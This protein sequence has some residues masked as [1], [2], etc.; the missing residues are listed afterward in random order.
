MQKYLSLLTLVLVWPLL[1]AEFLEVVKDGRSPYVVV[2]APDAPQAVR[3][4]ADDLREYIHKATG[5]QLPL[6]EAVQAA[7]KPSFRLGFLPVEQ[8]EGFVVKV[9][10][11]D[12]HISGNDTPGDPYNIHWA[13]GARVG[14]WYGVCD[15]LEKQLGVR[16]FMPGPLG[17]YVPQCPDLRVAAGLNYADAPRFEMR[18]MGYITHKKMSKSDARQCQ[19]WLR[20]NRAG[21]A[22]S[23]CAWHDWLFHFKG[24]DYFQEHPEWFALIGGRRYGT[25]SLGHGLKMCTTNP[26]AL[27]Q[28][29]KN[30]IE[31]RR[32][33]K[34]PIMLTLSPNDGGN[35]CECERCQA[36][37]NGVRPDG[38]RIMTDRMMTYAN[39][40]AKRVLQELPDQKFGMYAYGFFAEVG[41]VK[42]HPAITIEEVL[43][44]NGIS[45]YREEV[46]KNHLANLQGWRKNLDKL[47]FYGTP[48]GMGGLALPC[49]HFRNICLLYDNLYA[50][51]VTGFDMN[52]GSCFAASALNNYFYLRFAWADPGDRE[53]F[54]RQSLQQCYG[55]AAAPVVFACFEAL[56]Q[57][58]S[59]LAHRKMDE[60]R[61]LGYVKRYPGVITEVCAGF[62]EEW[63][64]QLQP[65]AAAASD[66]GQKAR[67]QLLLDN[68]EYSKTTCE[69][70]RL[71]MQVVSNPKPEVK[72]AAQ[73]D[74]LAQLRE[75]QLEK[76][77]HLPSNLG[78]VSHTEQNFRLPFDRNV[79]TYIM[80]AG[81][82]KSAKAQRRQGQ[83]VLDGRLDDPF[84][85]GLPVLRV[86]FDKN[87]GRVYAEG[88]DAKVAITAEALYISVRCEEPALDQIKDSGVG[89]EQA[90]WDENCV[91]IF[92]DP[93]GDGKLYYQLVFNSL[94]TYRAFSYADKKN[95]PWEVEP[96]VVT[97]RDENSWCAEACIPLAA[98]T[99]G[100]TDIRGDI[101][102]FNI[103]RAR[104]TVR[105]NAYSCWSPTFGD[106]HRPERFGRL[107]IQ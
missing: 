101:W 102:G 60:D 12:I 98:I 24:E 106:F 1:G 68:L 31:Y 5:A 100:K 85:A 45:Y 42:V 35:C 73:A 55:E 7:G 91:D 2:L 6:V 89:P 99:A 76:M 28:Y 93:A 88:A 37:D 10:N 107:I 13:N 4:A 95:T 3:A 96:K 59:Q 19:L 51:D 74:A 18:R 25:D 104:R 39:E 9:E 103:C 65:L 105:P 87:H 70:Y 23:W 56:E 26:E 54:Y 11:Q 50:A 34:R 46:R 86:Q 81:A 82:R 66:S 15:F 94:G 75:K 21:N 44:D 62:A 17:E 16:W 8:P 83:P 64:P 20:R 29:A 32:T 14:T 90:V 40:V 36:L 22:D 97:A 80:S 47:Y 71:A 78:S 61:G 79:F 53:Q 48:E 38:S 30:L 92:I 33:W 49:A 58:Y 84:W 57:R 41:N 72:I 69:L 63:L 52:N 27:D 43:N 77:T 67:L